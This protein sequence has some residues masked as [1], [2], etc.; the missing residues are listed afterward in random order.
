MPVRE[1]MRI[2]ISRSLGRAG[3]MADH[4]NV[5]NY[6]DVAGDRRVKNGLAECETKTMS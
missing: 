3:S 6:R 4:L 1:V 5:S 2:F